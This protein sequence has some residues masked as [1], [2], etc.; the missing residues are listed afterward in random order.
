LVAEDNEFNAQLLEQLLTRR[1]YWVRVANNGRAA[2]AL[3]AIKDQK[4]EVRSQK[5]EVG[6]GHALSPL[7]SDLRPLTSE[8]DLLR[9][10][11]HMQALDGFQVVQAFREREQT[12]GGHLPII[13]LT[14]RSRKEDREQCLAVGMDDFLAKPVQAADLWAT[15]DR[16]VANS[17]QQLEVR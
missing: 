12:T 5:S 9:L 4:S 7:T 10:Y 2:L 1:G 11:V 3:L 16:I 6:E 17:S 14:A 8:F 13:A 15:I